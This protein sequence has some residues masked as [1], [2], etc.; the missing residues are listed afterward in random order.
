VDPLGVMSLSTNQDTTRLPNPKLPLMDASAEKINNK[1]ASRSFE[2]NTSV[3]SAKR[4]FKRIMS[5]Q[6]CPGSRPVKALAKSMEKK[7]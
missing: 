3:T 7:R 2:K 6:I 4:T 1:P 5:Q